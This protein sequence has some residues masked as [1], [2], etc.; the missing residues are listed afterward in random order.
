MKS[1]YVS[2]LEPGKVVV[3][4]FLVHS[5]EVRQKKTGEPYLSL[6]L[7]DRTGEVDAKMWDNV[8]EV[9][10][11]FEPDDFV[12]VKGLL[13]IYNNR[14][15]LTVHKLQRL[16][17]AEVDPADYFPAS[18]R[19]P[20]EML[21]ELLQIVAGIRNPHLKALVELFLN[22]EEI[23]RRYKKAPAAKFIHHAY[24]GGLIEHV[25][26]LCHLCRLAAQ[27]YQTVDLD[28]L[29]TGAVLHD[30][31]KIY[32]LNYDRAFGYSSEGQLV[33]HIA[34]ALRLLERKLSLLPDFPERLRTLVEHL[35]LSHHGQL[36]FGSPK[37]PLFL[38]ALMLHYLDDLDAKMD[39]MRAILEQD[40]QVTGYWTGYS[41]SLE[42]VVLKKLKYLAGDQEE[43][44]EA[45][46]PT[47]PRKDERPPSLFGEKLGQAL[48]SLREDK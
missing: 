12:K 7:G 6:H 2:E 38:E 31:G 21:A 13:H 44:L 1:P 36:E 22:D 28:L 34:I 10:D 40:R 26:A 18:Q 4:T 29:L 11:T 9:V 19:D 24:L 17:D 42:R 48:D 32:E 45:A 37:V 20:D 8:A 27:C 47:P 5:K 3:T 14:P 33:G 43:L 39:C 23:A 41:T 30:V 15:Q 16:T 46:G 25:I 35:I